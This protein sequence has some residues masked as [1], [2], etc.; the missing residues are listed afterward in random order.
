V[1]IVARTSAARTRV[2]VGAR[3]VKDRTTGATVRT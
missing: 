2:T 1:A 3:A